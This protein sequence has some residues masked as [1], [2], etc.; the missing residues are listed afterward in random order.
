[1]ADEKTTFDKESILFTQLVLSFQASAM[2]Q[3]GKIKNPFTDAIERNISQAQMSIDMLTMLQ[4]KTKGNLTEEESRFLDHVLFELRMNYVDEIKKDQQVA[5]EKE[6]GVDE[7]TEDAGDA[8]P[9]KDH[10]VLRKEKKTVEDEE[11][12]EPERTEVK[13]QEKKESQRKKPAARAKKKKAGSKEKK[14]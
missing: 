7:A 8:I 9:E 6:E 14:L 2:Q 10:E 4:N 11:A 3:M 5:E 1:M 12:V 13:S